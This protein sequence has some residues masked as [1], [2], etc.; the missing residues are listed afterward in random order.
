MNILGLIPARGGS[1]GIPRK[2]VMPLLGKPLLAYTCEAAKQSKSLT[3][4]IVSTDDSEVAE[5][6]TSCGMSLDYP[7]PPEFCADDTPMAD[8][9]RHIIESQKKAGEP[10][11]IIVLLQPTSPLRTAE[12]IDEAVEILLSSN[13][14]TVVSV[15]P[16]PH[17]FN[18][19]SLM[20]REGESLVPNEEGG[21]VLRR[22]DK[23]LLYARNGPAILAM[24]AESF[25]AHGFY[26][27]D[28][29][30]YIMDSLSSI[31]V[32]ALDDALHAEFLLH[33]KAA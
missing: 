6:A 11:D 2:N 26:G 31:D 29:R 17:R 32:D 1:K 30:P 16:V 18:P 8:V 19:S 3:R 24:R 13:A 7:R 5:V 4:T 23:P 21:G 12:H 15:V 25:L 33:K 27:G 10:V 14:D 20:R 28:T 22:Q 9:V